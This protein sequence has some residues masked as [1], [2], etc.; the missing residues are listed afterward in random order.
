MNQKEF[1]MIDLQEKRGYSNNFKVPEFSGYF[2]NIKEL[3]G[4]LR[5]AKYFTGGSITLDLGIA[6]KSWRSINKKGGRDG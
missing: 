3:Q 2:K 4:F 1:F 5:F 6:F